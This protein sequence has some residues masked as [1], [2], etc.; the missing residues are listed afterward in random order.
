MP[1]HRAV[2]AGMPGVYP[3]HPPTSFFRF[4]GE[5]L[6]KLCPPRVLHPLGGAGAGQS[7]DV[8]VFVDDGAI[9][10]YEPPG[11]FVVEVFA[12]V[13]DFAVQLGYPPSGLTAAVATPLLPGQ[14]TLGGGEPGLGLLEVPGGLDQLPVGGNQ[15]VG[16]GAQVYSNSVLVFRKRPGLYLAT[17]ND[18]PMFAFPLPPLLELDPGSP[19]L[20]D[21]PLSGRAIARTP[22]GR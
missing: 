16:V 8:Q 10:V 2:L 3:H 12:L 21:D 18:V 22:R 11:E 15:K 19:G 6:Q 20:G 9:A 7:E 14:A 13:G 5:D 1:S 17:E 4:V